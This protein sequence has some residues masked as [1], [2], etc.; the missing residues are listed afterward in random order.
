M[1]TVK[2]YSERDITICCSTCNKSIT[3]QEI[4][5]TYLYKMEPI[6]DISIEP[7]K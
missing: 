6:K 5:F 1:N 3:V 4:I 2:D 7:T